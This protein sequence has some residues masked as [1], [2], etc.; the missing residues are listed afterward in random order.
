[1]TARSKLF[2]VLLATSALML[3]ACGGDGSEAG[4]DATAT[5]LQTG[6]VGA[7]ESAETRQHG[8]SLVV[9]LESETNTYATDGAGTFAASG[10]M[11]AR[12]I[13]DPL[14]TLA[15]DGRLVPFLAADVYPNDGLTEW[16]VELRAEVTFHDGTAL[17]ADTL[18]WNFDT[19]HFSETSRNRATLDNFGVTGMEVVDDQTVRYLLS[20][21]NAGFPEL[22][23]GPI[24]WPVSRAAFESDPDGYGSHP[25][26][27][28]PFAFVSWTTDSHLTVERN[29]SYW[30]VDPETGDALPYLDGIEFRILPDHESRVLSLA[31]DDIQVMHTL[32]GSVVQRVLSMVDEGGFD[33]SVFIGNTASATMINTAVAPLDD[34]RIRRAMAHANDLDALSQV[35]GDDGLVPPARG[36]FSQESPWFS[37]DAVEAYPTFDL[38]E[39]AALVA[40]YVNDPTRSDGRAVG[41]P[42]APVTYHCQPDPSLLEQAQL[43]QS[44]FE[45]IGIRVELEQLDQASMIQRVIG[46]A[47][48]DPP[49]VGDYTLAC[50]RA[51]AGDGDPLQSLQN[52]FGPVESTPSN[53]SNFTSPDVDDALERLRTSPGFDARYQAAEDINRV[54][55]QEVPVLWSFATPAV[56]GYRDDVAGITGWTTPDGTRGAGTVGA[57]VRW[58][59][60]HLVD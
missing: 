39:A 40:D 5:S 55:A 10:L 29:E 18:K 31:A 19:L 27:T 49:F 1:M 17:D 35:R 25:V 48:T 8:G 34:Q 46:S 33:A 41:D 36:F 3:A 22:L 4:A 2:L 12:A 21:P 13:Y 7:G 26:G 14:V 15:E 57:T 38:A 28:G 60:V 59:Q 24:G 53:F 52:F 43:V 6:S 9:G 50:F 30:M 11:V 32:R 44:M 23:Q 37:A 16:T 58:H 54:A 47:D 56:V 20:E 45:P 51:G 42:V